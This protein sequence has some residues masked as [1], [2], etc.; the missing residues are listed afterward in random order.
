MMGI[1]YYNKLYRNAFH[2]AWL[3]HQAE[4]HTEDELV[5]SGMSLDSMSPEVAEKLT[6]GVRQAQLADAMKL[7]EPEVFQTTPRLEALAD[8]ASG[9]TRIP[10]KYDPIY[11][12]VVERYRGTIENGGVV[13]VVTSFGSTTIYQISTAEELEAY[14]ADP[15]SFD[16]KFN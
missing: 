4:G 3:L 6:V 14:I 7:G 16:G 10:A 9:A 2:E 12:Y 8:L 15:D 13:A 5:F 1:D 11:P